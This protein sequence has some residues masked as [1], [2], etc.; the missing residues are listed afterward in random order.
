MFKNQWMELIEDDRFLN[1]DK[2]FHFTNNVLD[3]LFT[4]GNSLFVITNRQFQKKAI[5]QLEKYQLLHYFKK[6]FVTQQNFEK[7][8]LISTSNIVLTE[9]DY[10][11][12]D[13]GKDIQAGKDLGLKTVAVLSGFRN[14]DSLIT[15]KPDYI[16][17]NISELPQII[18]Q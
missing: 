10:F 1:M 7:Q 8:A 14:Y 17:N 4:Q 16:L 11:I 13:T 15:Y 5:Q 12:G 6:V 2:P 9:N 3:Q 18:H